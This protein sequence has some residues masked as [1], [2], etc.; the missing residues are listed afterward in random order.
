[1]AMLP[2]KDSGIRLSTDGGSR[3]P[4][5]CLALP[6]GRGSIVRFALVP[7]RRAGTLSREAPAA[8]AANFSEAY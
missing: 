1:M 6:V 5:R 4:F 2:R 3:R 8:V 7:I